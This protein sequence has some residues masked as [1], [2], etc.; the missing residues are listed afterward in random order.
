MEQPEEKIDSKPELVLQYEP[1]TQTAK[2]RHDRITQVERTVNTMRSRSNTSYLMS[3]KLS[4]LTQNQSET[5]GHSNSLTAIA[6][7]NT[8]PMVTAII[9]KQQDKKFDSNNNNNKVKKSD[10]ILKEIN[11]TFDQSK[12]L[13]LTKKYEKYRKQEAEDLKKEEEKQRKKLEKKKK[14]K[15]KN[16][17]RK[18]RK[19]KKRKS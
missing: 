2:I 17:N 16:K 9:Q 4:E 3:K 10:I 12:K 6:S 14:R 7:T 1:V 13:K 19:K 8:N 5:P 11:A 15:K 18:K